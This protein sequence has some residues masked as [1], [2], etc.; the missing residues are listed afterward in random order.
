MIVHEGAES[1]LNRNYKGTE[2]SSDKPKVSFNINRIVTDI[3]PVARESE[4]NENNEENNGTLPDE[5]NERMDSDS[6][7]DISMDTGE[8]TDD[9]NFVGVVMGEQVLRNIRETTDDDVTSLNPARVRPL[10]CPLCNLHVRFD[11]LGM[12]IDDPMFTIDATETRGRRIIDIEA[13]IRYRIY[14]HKHNSDPRTCKCSEA[15]R[16]LSSHGGLQ[17][18]PVSFKC[19]LRYRNH[20]HDTS[21]DPPMDG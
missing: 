3:I 5:T 7:L 17:R 1:V 20:I 19:L 11:P 21:G 9:D 18:L 16:M 14:V 2:V 13:Y 12:L 15:I 10:R 4:R 8:T 6:D